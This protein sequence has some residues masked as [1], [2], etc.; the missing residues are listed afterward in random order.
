MFL[1]QKKDSKASLMGQ[2][3]GT[4]GSEQIKDIRFTSEHGSSS[5][6]LKGHRWNFSA[7]LNNKDNKYILMP[8]NI[9][10]DFKFKVVDLLYADAYGETYRILLGKKIQQ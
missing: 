9:N 10:L 6:L 8:T 3:A 1:E 4:K 2:G 5:S 7:Q